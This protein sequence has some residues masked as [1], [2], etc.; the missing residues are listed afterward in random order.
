[1]FFSIRPWLMED[2]NT[3]L[4]LRTRVY[5]CKEIYVLRKNKPRKVYIDDNCIKTRS[6]LAEEFRWLI[7]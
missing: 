2:S 5:E 3:R 6:Y 4:G 7:F 1:M